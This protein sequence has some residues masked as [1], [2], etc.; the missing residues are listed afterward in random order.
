MREDEHV[1]KAFAALLFKIIQQTRISLFI[2]E[3]QLWKQF[4]IFLA[5][6]QQR[7]SSFIP[8][9]SVHTL[10]QFTKLKPKAK[11]GNYFS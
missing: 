2:R 7:T 11:N 9:L 5:L 1:E 4:S 8:R 6:L 10:Q 3:P